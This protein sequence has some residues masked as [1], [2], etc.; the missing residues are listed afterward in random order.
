MTLD[1]KID[2][3]KG[4]AEKYEWKPEWFG[5]SD[6]NGE[7]VSKIKEFQK[8]HG[9]SPDG[10]CGP[11]TYRRL[12]T[13]RESEID[14]DYINQH[15]NAKKYIVHNS[16]PVEIHWDKVI[17]WND[18]NGLSCRKGSYTDRSGK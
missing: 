10:L 7:L 18:D 15:S 8:E 12:F 2:Y 9:L 16:T 11:S 5:A 13:E 14:T 3:N 4:Q 1:Q 6:F 17:L